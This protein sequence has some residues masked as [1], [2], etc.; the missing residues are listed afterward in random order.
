MRAASGLRFL[1]AGAAAIGPL[2][3]VLRAADLFVAGTIGE[4]YKGDSR[5]GGFE[6]FGGICL[7]P[8]RALAYDAASVYA[9]DQNGGIV[10]LDLATGAFIDLWW[11]PGSNAS[12]IVV[13]QGDLLVSSTFG[14]I[15]RVDPITQTV[16][17]TMT[18]PIQIQAMALRGDDLFIA[19]TVGEV[20]KGNAL[21]G[22]FQPYAGICLGPIQALALSDS[23]IYAGDLVGAVARFDLATGD[24]M[25]ASFIPH[26]VTALA[27]DGDGVL[28]SEQNGTIWRLNPVN[29]AILDSLISPIFIDAMDILPTVGDLDGDGQVGITDFLALLQEWGPCAGPPAPCPAD[30]DGDGEVGIVDFLTLLGNWG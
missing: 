6:Q 28:A 20:Y 7:S 1:A 22:G 18:S 17:S 19:G 4:V 16:V 11:V 14:T 3:P 8:V 26:S 27:W 15:H 25:G 30:L 9:G 2:C 13:H 10:Q 12:D 29:G 24:F 5:T 21:T 23:T